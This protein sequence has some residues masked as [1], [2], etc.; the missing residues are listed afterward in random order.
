[1]TKPRSLGRVSRVVLICL[2]I[3][4]MSSLFPAGASGASIGVNEAANIDFVLGAGGSISGFVRDGGG[5][6]V[7]GATVHALADASSVS[8]YDTTAADGSYSIVNLTPGGYRVDVTAAG[9]AGEY[10]G[11]LYAPPAAPNVTVADLTDTP[12]ID[13]TL[14]PGGSISGVVEDGNGD[15]IELAVVSATTEAHPGGTSFTDE[16]GTYLISNLAPGSYTVQ[17]YATGYVWE[18]YDGVY[19]EPAGPNVA[20]AD[21]AD[22]PNVDFTLGAGGSI[23]G[24]VTDAGGT[25]IEG[26]SVSAVGTFF[27]SAITGADGTFTI[28]TLAPGSYW[29]SAKADGYVSEYYNDVY[30]IPLAPNVAVTDQA[31]TPD[32]DFALAVGGSISG[33]VRNEEGSPIQNATVRAV[34]NSLAFVQTGS[35][36]GYSLPHLAAGAYMVSVEADGYVDEYYSNVYDL[37][38]ATAVA[39]T[40]LTNTP[41]IDFALGPGGSISGFVRDGGGDPIEGATVHAWQEHSWGDDLTAAD[42]SYTITG[43]APGDYL[44]QADANGYALEYYNGVYTW[45]A[46]TTVHVVAPDASPPTMPVVTDDGATTSNAG[47]LHAWWTATD[48]ESGIAEYQ[49][50]IGTTSGGTDVVG[51]TSAGTATEVTKTGLSLTVGSTYYISVKAANTAGLWSGVGTSDGISVIAPDTTPPATPVVTDDGATTT[52]AGQLHASWTAADAESGVAAYQYAIGTTSGGV[53]VVGWT[54]AGTATEV[55]KTGLSL[56]V[57][58]TYYI[59]VKACNGSGLWSEVGSSDG[60]KLA[61]PPDATPPTTPV[62]TDDG[63][64]TESTSQL[65]A[66]WT[67]ADAES[68]VAE[69]QYAIGTTSGG[70]DVVGWT[71]TGTDAQVTRTGLVLTPGATYYFSVKARNGQEAWSGAG[72]SDGIAVSARDTVEKGLSESGGTVVTPDGKVSAEFPEGAV[73]GDVTVTI[74]SADY[75]S[76]KEAP[77]GF[78]A[79]GVCFVIQVT[80]AG[81]NPV[82]TLDEP[83]VITVKYT[84]ADLDALGGDPGQLVLAYYDEEAGDWVT[85]KTSVDTESMTL[86]AS[87]THL[88]TWAIMQD[89][90]TAGGG[91]PVWVW[92][93][94]GIAAVLGVGGAALLLSRR[95]ARP[96]Q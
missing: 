79:G 22:T 32:I 35:D 56:T 90:G 28:T 18:Y 45:P 1:M 49:Y 75:P 44:V 42:G 17:A 69:Y 38:S 53:D 60:I 14:G 20:V 93:I 8:E 25:P 31:D 15:P 94:V 57:G 96:Q 68:G 2:V 64:T 47:Q 63:A 52:D 76:D 21:L 19:E 86:S 84:Q 13:F 59:S 46:A 11:G 82:S 70:T 77:A 30:Q 34:G 67:A 72:S 29:V 73:T 88:S 66:S 74:E 7:E 5:T 27:G 4:A 89:T 65:H 55:T 10:Y 36:G 80:D 85:L 24:V 95:S 16:N 12:G 40:D 33:F 23:S 26:A 41:G 78:K 71:S 87:T 61:A 92:V 83:V 39:V 43:L 91:T 48:A 9:Y 81:G 58:S 3:W 37:L 6:P 51:W 50:A 62:V 54:S